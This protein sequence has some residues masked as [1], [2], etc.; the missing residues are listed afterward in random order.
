MNVKRYFLA[1][2]AVY[3]FLHL[4]NWLFTDLILTN[5]YAQIS[6]I[7]HLDLI[8]RT[9]L[10]RHVTPYITH[11]I[12]AFALVYLYVKGFAQKTFGSGLIYGLLVSIIVCSISFIL[13]SSLPIPTHLMI[14]WILLLFVEITLCGIVAAWVYSNLYRDTQ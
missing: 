14:V 9:D 5:I 10:F 13:F 3:L 1:V 8:Q 2:I 7:L 12:F 6:Q 4:Y 11:V